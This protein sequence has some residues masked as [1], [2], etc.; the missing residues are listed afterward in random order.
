MISSKLTDQ[1]DNVSDGTFLKLEKVTS[2]AQVTKR[3]IW[4]YFTSEDINEKRNI[5][6]HKELSRIFKNHT[7]L[8]IKV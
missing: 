2:V 6:S 5:I 7:N 4:L 1:R 8:K 3:L